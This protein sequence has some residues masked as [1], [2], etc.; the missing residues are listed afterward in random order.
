MT[1]GIAETNA[2]DWVTIGKDILFYVVIP[3]AVI[4]GAQK[5]V[6]ALRDYMKTLWVEGKPNEW[7]L[8]MRNG[9]MVRA[10]I[11]LRCFRGPFD[12]VA[13]FPARIYKVSFDAEQVTSEMQ[14]VRV[15]GM[16][17][18]TVNRRGTGPF[19]AYKNLGDISSGNPRSANESLVAEAAAV[20]RGCIANSTIEEMIRNRAMLRDAISKEMVDVVK[21]WGVWLETI[22]ITDVKISSQSLFKDLQTNYRE[23]MRQQATLH[24]A[25][26]QEQIA[27]EKNKN[28]IMV[29]EK[30]RQANEKTTI[31]SGKIDIETK[32]EQERF[33]AD[34]VE[35]NKEKEELNVQHSI[36]IEAIKQKLKRDLE[37]IDLKQF[38][39]SD[40]SRIKKNQESQRLTVE[41]N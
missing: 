31:Y 14:G 20:V 33:M 26:I 6:V 1:E 27:E 8:I 19:E 10:A 34:K 21:G 30:E 11:G 38:L 13:R 36:K 24:R 9:E 37:Q 7:V 40:K 5:G 23:S 28:S 16:L 17:V 35:I 39:E 25:E 2:I 22:E 32:E 12:Q 15:S 29:Q 41:K 4:M 3:I 18:W